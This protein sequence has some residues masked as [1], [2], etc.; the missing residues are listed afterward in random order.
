MGPLGDKLVE[1]LYEELTLEMLA[2]DAAKS[3]AAPTAS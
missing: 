2:L 1:K 3:F